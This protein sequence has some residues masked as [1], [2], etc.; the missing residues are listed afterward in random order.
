MAALEKTL[1]KIFITVDSTALIEVNDSPLCIMNASIISIGTVQQVRLLFCYSG[2]GWVVC[3]SKRAVRAIHKIWHY[4]IKCFREYFDFALQP[5]A[6][7]F[8]ELARQSS[9]IR[10]EQERLDY[11][12]FSRAR[13]LLNVHSR[14]YLIGSFHWHRLGISQPRPETLSFSLSS[15]ATVVTRMDTSEIRKKKSWRR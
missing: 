11:T 13:Q 8:K 12:L 10:S 15:L 14:R 4:D 5:F 9:P 7:G 6:I 2:S 1:Y 3:R